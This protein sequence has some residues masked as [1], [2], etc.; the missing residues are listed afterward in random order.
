M[1]ERALE[2]FVEIVRTGSFTAAAEA[3]YISQSALSQQVRALE[4][5]MGVDLFDHSY[6]RVVLT[7]AG[8]DFYPRAQQLLAFYH[9]AVHAAK[10]ASQTETL[11]KQF[12]LFGCTDYEFF[13]LWLD[14]FRITFERPL[15]YYPM[16]T[17]FPSRDK[18]Y[19]AL[20]CGEI[21]FTLQLEN[22]I[23]AARGFEFIPL[24]HVPEYG[25]ALN[26]QCPPDQKSVTPEDT[27]GY[28][29]VF[30]HPPGYTY[31]EDM[32]RTYARSA[33]CP[34]LENEEFF[35]RD[36]ITPTLLLLPSTEYPRTNGN[37]ALPLR[38]GDGARLGFVLRPN[39][40]ESVRDYAHLVQQQILANGLPWEL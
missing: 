40:K 14:L 17:R 37:Y 8:E 21:D 10:R 38:W 26:A 2:G 3:L 32:L 36:S 22:D 20:S 28:Q 39:A 1:N 7:A 5:Q 15:A 12:L 31:Y 19:Q 29:L 34:I 24:A 25:V 9:D 13:R 23:V 30:H 16:A 11:R 33:G 35:R 4:A 6:R 18:I 27:G